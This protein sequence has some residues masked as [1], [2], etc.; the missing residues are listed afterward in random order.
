[1][2]RSPRERSRFDAPPRRRA[3]DTP[4][5]VAGVQDD[6]AAPKL[7]R[8]LWGITVLIAQPMRVHQPCGCH[9]LG[10]A[11][12]NQRAFSMYSTAQATAAEAVPAYHAEAFTLVL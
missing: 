4:A 2:A 5:S 3:L 9:P 11:S 1:M 12:A 10:E 7:K 6:A 8:H